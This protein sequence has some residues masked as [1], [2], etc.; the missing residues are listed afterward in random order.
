MHNLKQLAIGIIKKCHPK[1]WG[2]HKK[3]SVGG[4]S[5][6]HGLFCHSEIEFFKKNSPF[7]LLLV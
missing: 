2:S 7:R 4:V 6:S 3:S 5:P 1:N